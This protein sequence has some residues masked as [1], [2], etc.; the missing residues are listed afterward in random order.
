VL[1][2]QEDVGVMPA[3]ERMRVHNRPPFAALVSVPA[4]GISCDRLG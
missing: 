3:L 1:F 4:I 2:A